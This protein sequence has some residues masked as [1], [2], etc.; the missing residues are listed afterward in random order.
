MAGE[1]FIKGDVLIL[2]VH[3]GTS[4][5]PVACLTSNSIST[6]LSTIDTITKCDPGKTIKTAGIFDYSISADGLYIDTGVG[7]DITKVSHDTLLAYQMAGTAVTWSISTGLTTN[8]TYYGT[9]IISDLNLD[10]PTAGENSTFSATL[11]GSGAIVLV[12]PIP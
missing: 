1:S 11:N 7:G 5:L 9:A 4:Y 3:D 2:S 10:A 12:D 6:N 8:T